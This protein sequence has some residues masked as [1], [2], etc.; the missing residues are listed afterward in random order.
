M[1][2]PTQTPRS[3]L[4]IFVWTLQFLLAALFVFAGAS[5]FIMPMAEMTK[6]MPLPPWFL[7][8]IGVAEV[9]GGLGLVLPGLLRIRPGLTAWAAI[10][11]VVI[12]LGATVVS[13]MSGG[14]KAAI[15]PF[16]CGLGCA[17]IA[18]R[19]SALASRS[20]QPQLA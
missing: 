3:A 19:R 20:A 1:N 14:P 15:M 2:A 16:V 5:K 9:L 13:W 12:M 10:G 11:L 18:Y 6:Q 7:Y 4:N 17:F 8:F